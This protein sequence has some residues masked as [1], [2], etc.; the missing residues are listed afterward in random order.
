[1]IDQFIK[2]IAIDTLVICRY[3]EFEAKLIAEKLSP[4]NNG[5]LPST[6]EPQIKD[7]K[8]EEKL[9]EVTTKTDKGKYM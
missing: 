9:E 8:S 1:M 6:D 5:S 7:D 4:L 3:E 2:T